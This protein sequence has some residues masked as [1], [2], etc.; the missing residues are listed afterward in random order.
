MIPS[1]N[2]I[3]NLKME[4]IIKQYKLGLKNLNLKT[5]II[6]KHALNYPVF[7]K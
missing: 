4:L 3:L 5:E 1:S 6:T 2:A 7:G